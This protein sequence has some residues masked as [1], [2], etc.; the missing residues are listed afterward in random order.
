MRDAALAFL[1]SLDGY[2]RALAQWTWPSDDE[3]HRWFYTPTD[4]GGLPLSSMTPH[5]QQRALAL[6]AAGTSEAGYN[7]AVTIIGLDNAL[8][9]TEGFPSRPRMGRERFRDPGL[10]YV[11]VFGTPGDDRWSCRIGGHHLS[12]HWTFVDGRMVS[13]TPSFM[14]ADPA[15][16]PLVGGVLLRPLAAYEDLGRELVRALPDAI[17]SPN[18][19]DDIAGGNRPRISEGDEPMA[20]LEIFRDDLGPQERPSSDVRLGREGV[21]V[22]DVDIARTLLDAYADRLPDEHRPAFDPSGFR[23]VWAGG[24]EAGERHYYRLADDRWVIEYDN[25]QRDVNHI[26]AVLREWTGDFGHDALRAHLR[27]HDHS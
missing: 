24:T 5:Q 20:L 21:S 1:D 25:T 15:S 19:P 22:A 17:V 12:L 7:T 3:R 16:S 10:Y 27:E 13:T 11:R 9:R 6:L 8:D 2:Q 14:G 23:F 4:H 26:H 18:A